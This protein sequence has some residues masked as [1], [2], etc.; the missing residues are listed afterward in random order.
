MG[1]MFF[2]MNSNNLAFEMS[3]NMVMDMEGNIFM[4]ISD[5]MAIDSKGNMFMLMQDNMVMDMNA[6]EMHF[7]Y[8]QAGDEQEDM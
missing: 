6:G 2:D 5:N 8:T 7:I 4:R 3:D 1:K